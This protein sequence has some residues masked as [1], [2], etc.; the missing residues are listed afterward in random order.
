MGKSYR[1][2]SRWK[3]SKMCQDKSKQ[4]KSLLGIKEQLGVELTASLCG[5]LRGLKERCSILNTRLLFSTGGKIQPGSM[6]DVTN[7]SPRGTPRDKMITAAE[8]CH[9]WVNDQSGQESQLGTDNTGARSCEVRAGNSP[10]ISE[11]L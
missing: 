8:M 7:T 1:Q 11:C 2:K 9:R 10:S 5:H 3:T 6:Q 4:M